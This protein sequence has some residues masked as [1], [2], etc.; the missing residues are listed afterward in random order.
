MSTQSVIYSM[1]P[2]TE[3]VLATFPESTPPLLLPRSVL[4]QAYGRP[5]STTRGG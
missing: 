5:I 2:A 1:N 3:E 4:V